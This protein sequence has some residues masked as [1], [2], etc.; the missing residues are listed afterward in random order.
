[1]PSISYVGAPDWVQWILTLT[2][3]VAALLGLLALVRKVWPILTRFVNTINS[4]ADLPQFMVTTAAT[5]AYQDE[6]IAEIHHEVHYNNGSS[7]KDS[8][9]RTEADVAELKLTVAGIDEGVKGMYPRLDDQDLRF[10][11]ADQDRADL[12]EDLEQTRPH[13]P[14]RKRPAKPKEP[15]S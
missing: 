10:D 5:L 12:R 3:I 4:L 7:V 2:I 11:S 15:T 9:A 13:P 8:Q 14:A 6:K 1:M